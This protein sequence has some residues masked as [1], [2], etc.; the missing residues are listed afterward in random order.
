M[1]ASRDNTTA[2]ASAPDTLAPDASAPGPSA[3]DLGAPKLG[4]SGSGASHATA[5]STGHA[6]GA[7]HP[8]ALPPI[9]PPILP[10]ILA[11][12][13]DLLARY[14]VIFC[15]VWG[16]VHD[17][18]DA[19][20][21][22]CDAL[23]RFRAKGGTVIL[24]SNAPVPQHRVAAMLAERRVPRSA[25]D[26]IVSSG[27]IAL[28]HV[29]EAGYQ[30]LYT[31]GPKARDSALF[32]ALT[33]ASVPLLEAEAIICTGLVDDIHETEE[34]YRPLLEVAKSRRLPF[35]C[36]N[37]DLVVDVAGTLYLCAGA[38]A[39]LYARMGGS[40]FWAG[41]PYASAYASAHA[42]AERLRGASVPKSRIIAVGDAVRT[43]LTGAHRAGVDA[44]FIAAGI[45]REELVR[46][47][48][49]C[50]D[51][52]ARLLAAPAPQPVAV[53]HKLAW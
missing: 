24:V 16:V 50:A 18:R 46:D 48:A 10:P 41:K 25:W 12:G 7:A 2:P 52:L 33:A 28:R 51:R 39:D 23:Q 35:V 5:A 42:A 4:A 8:A 34:T 43:D 53:M 26:E 20:A 37:P 27:D 3:P 9:P 6:P 31:I 15:D 17:G 49:I 13:G 29:A 1:P 44:L 14:D 36:A 38:I 32:G 19:Y 47:G 45:H 11:H 22:A 21:T 40:V 30:R